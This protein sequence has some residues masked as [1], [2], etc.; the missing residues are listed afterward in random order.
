MNKKCLNF[1][2]QVRNAGNDGGIHP[3]SKVL[4]DHDIQWLIVKI[5]ADFIFPMT[6]NQND[7]IDTGLLVKGN[8]PF[9][10]CLPAEFQQWLE[11][12]HP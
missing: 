6:Q 7:L 11:S 3:L 2:V 5:G 10:R 12:I 9:H 4:I 8:H 1:V